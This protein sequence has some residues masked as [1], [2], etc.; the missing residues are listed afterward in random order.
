MILQAISIMEDQD[1]EYNLV[2]VGEG[3]SRAELEELAVELDINEQVWFFGHLYDE[4][5]IGQLLFDSDLCVSPGNV[6]LTAMHSLVYGTPIITHGNFQNQMPEFESIISGKSGDFFE[7]NNIQNLVLKVVQWL[8]NH[9]DRDVVRKDCRKSIES[10]Y[11]PE[12]QFKIIK[13]IIDENSN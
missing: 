12:Y 8:E 3:E 2:L 7:E 11:N 6:G 4:E 9:T 13:Q 5:K 10:K 1:Q